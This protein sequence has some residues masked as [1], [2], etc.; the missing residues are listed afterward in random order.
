MIAVAL[1]TGSDYTE[2][3]D[4]VGPIGAMEIL[5]EF[6]GPGLSALHAFR[7]DFGKISAFYRT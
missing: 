7:S 3:I 2:G 4:S 1:M 5:S 6:G